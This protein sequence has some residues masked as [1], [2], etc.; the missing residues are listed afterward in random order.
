MR[1]QMSFSSK[2]L[3]LRSASRTSCSIVM[4]KNMF[5]E[6]DGPSLE[7]LHKQQRRSASQLNASGD[8][9]VLICRYMADEARNLKAYA[10]LPEHSK[11]KLSAALFIAQTEGFIHQVMSCL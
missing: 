4:K 5:L 10:E 7:T 8:R 6:I 2:L 3:R 11:L 9:L 1:R